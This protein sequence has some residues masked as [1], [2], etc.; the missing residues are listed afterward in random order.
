MRPIVHRYTV[1][2]DDPDIPCLA[3]HVAALAGI[4]RRRLLPTLTFSASI[5][6][7]VV[8]AAQLTKWI[9]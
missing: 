4:Y 9:S 6:G 5:L 2:L 3:R 8:I 1:I 7:T